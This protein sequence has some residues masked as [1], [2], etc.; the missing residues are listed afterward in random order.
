MPNIPLAPIDGLDGKAGDNAGVG[1]RGT[2]FDAATFGFLGGTDPT[3][4]Q[5]AG[6]YGQSIN[7]GVM[8]LSTSNTGTG[9]YGGGTTSNTEYGGIGV[10]GETGSG[11]AVLSCAPSSP[12]LA[13]P[14]FRN[15]I[16]GGS[17][18]TP[19]SL[20]PRGCGACTGTSAGHRRWTTDLEPA[21]RSPLLGSTRAGRRSGCARGLCDRRG[22]DSSQ[23]GRI[24]FAHDC[25][26]DGIAPAQASAPRV[27]SP[28][29]PPNTP[30][31]QSKTSARNFP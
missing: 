29:T 9:V 24:H 14:N 25:A 23:R 5:A 18:H 27:E 10:R 28:L 1:V 13:S 22:H 7:Q 3:F 21:I 4:S 31:W 6:V 2:S 30:S 15:S 11:C 20:D 16:K 17:I 19:R 8:G 12:A 26:K